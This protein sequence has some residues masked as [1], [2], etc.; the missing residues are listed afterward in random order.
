[1]SPVEQ[2]EPTWGNGAPRPLPWHQPHGGRITLPTSAGRTAGRA[3]PQ[4]PASHLRGARCGHVKGARALEDGGLA[5]PPGTGPAPAAGGG[6]P[7]AAGPGVG[8][9]CWGTRCPRGLVARGCPRLGS[10]V[11]PRGC[12]SLW[13]CQVVV[14][15]RSTVLVWYQ[16]V[17]L[18]MAWRVGRGTPVHHSSVL[19]GIQ[20]K[21]QWG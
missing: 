9:G 16:F 14:G 20:G 2:G 11:R 8:D 6:R 21:L 3:I 19:R 17:G 1:M 12:C 5:A 4:P 7:P 13:L 15:P 10:E 18:G